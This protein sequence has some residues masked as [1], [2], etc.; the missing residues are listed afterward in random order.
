METPTTCTKSRIYSDLDRAQ[1]AQAALDSKARLRTLDAKLKALGWYVYQV[2]EFR[3]DVILPIPG[4]DVRVHIM[5]GWDTD[6]RCLSGCLC[7]GPVVHHLCSRGA[8]PTQDDITAWRDMVDDIVAQLRNIKDQSR[9]PIYEA[10][11]TGKDDLQARAFL[12]I[13][14]RLAALENAGR[15]SARDAI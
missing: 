15:D 12:A 7:V 9:D 5:F 10:I 2:H 1:F 6:G 11:Y 8:I 14:Q 4:G 3:L 13:A